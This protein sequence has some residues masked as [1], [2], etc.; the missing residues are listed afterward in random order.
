MGPSMIVLSL[1]GVL[2][3]EPR[4]SAPEALVLP[5][6]DTPTI[7]APLGRLRLTVLE[8]AGTRVKSF[9]RIHEHEEGVKS[10]KWLKLEVW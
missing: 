4:L 1:A 6:D 8:S 3:F 5:L 9:E 7:T 10:A 2:G